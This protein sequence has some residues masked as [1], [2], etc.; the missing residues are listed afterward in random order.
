MNAWK[1]GVVMA[2]RSTPS[3]T[4]LTMLAGFSQISQ[5]V[6]LS[7]SPS[8]HGDKIWETV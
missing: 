7:F 6:V 5:K 8:F 3:L 2:D 4:V 1:M